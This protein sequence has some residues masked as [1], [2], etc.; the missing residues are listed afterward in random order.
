LGSIL[1]GIDNE[2]L[3]QPSPVVSPPIGAPPT[4]TSSAPASESASAPIG[5][6]VSRS[7]GP[8][9]TESASS[10]VTGLISAPIT[11]QASPLAHRVTLDSTHTNS[12]KAVYSILY[13]ETISFGRNDIYFRMRDLLRETGIRSKQTVRTA[14]H[15]LE[16]KL[17]IDFRFREGD[18]YGGVYHVYG[19]KEIF[20]ARKVAG[21]E[22]D[23]TSKRIKSRR[24]SGP[25]TGSASPPISDG[26]G[27]HEIQSASPLEISPHVFNTKNNLPVPQS[28]SVPS[29]DKLAKV[30]K[31]FEQLSNGGTWKEERDLKA[32]EQ[33]A[34]VNLFHITL[35][36]CYSVTKSPEHKMSSLAYAVNSILRHAEDMSEYPDTVLGEIAYKTKRT[37]MNCIATGNWTIPEWQQG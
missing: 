29:D 28:S 36:L 5:Q 17:S 34:R 14:V 10:P 22:I 25:I 26:D 21:I 32:Y 2:E 37:T 31:L 9:I 11:G 16:S 15:G 12:E 7:A 23:P 30:R 33:I 20:A 13:R 1:A 3:N 27:Y 24:V 4:D 35:G 6:P 8:P 18:V 19:P